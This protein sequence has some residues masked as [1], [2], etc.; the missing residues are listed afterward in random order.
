MNL[1]LVRG[2]EDGVNRVISKLFSC[3]SGVLVLLTMI[4]SLS[5][6]WETGNDRRL[7][8][9]SAFGFGRGA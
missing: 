6:L 4:W 9:C 2:L 7:D 5:V 1:F 3:I 8:V